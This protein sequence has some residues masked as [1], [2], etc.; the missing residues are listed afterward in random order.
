MGN[1]RVRMICLRFLCALLFNR[2]KL[3]TPH[4]KGQP[5]HEATA[6]QA[7]RPRRLGWI[8]ALMIS[9]G[10]L[11]DLCVRKTISEAPAFAV[12]KVTAGQEQAPTGGASS[13]LLQEHSRHDTAQQQRRCFYGRLGRHRRLQ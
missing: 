13:K 3:R 2:A 8:E 5:S 1:M 4:A 10:V 9:L 7:Q 12:A 6:W 11:R